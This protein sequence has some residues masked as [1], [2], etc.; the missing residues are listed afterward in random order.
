MEQAS[1]PAAL[2]VSQTWDNM[3]VGMGLANGAA[4]DMRVALLTAYAEPARAY[5]TLEHIAALLTLFDTHGSGV[6]DRDAVLLAILYHD[7]V[8]DP[9]RADNEAASARLATR[10][11]AALGAPP[12]LIGRVAALVLATQ[13][14][15]KPADPMDT[16]LCLLLDLDL[17]VLAAAPAA[18]DA[19]AAAIRREYTHVPSLLYRPGRRKVLQHF[20]NT[21]PLYRTQPLAAR[22]DAA[23]RQNLRREIAGL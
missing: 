1:V 19:Y 4:S 21:V 8:Y 14:G 15:A 17:S 7:V 22:W 2:R 5:H 12:A 18:Y 13:H 10:D 20:L 11:L 16:D 9:K 23:A 6:V 3:I